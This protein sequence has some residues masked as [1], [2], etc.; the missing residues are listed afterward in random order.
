[1]QQRIAKVLLHDGST[2]LVLCRMEDDHYVI[3]EGPVV[4]GRWCR[5]IKPLGTTSFT[6]AKNQFT[7]AVTARRHKDFGEAA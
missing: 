4:N 2:D 1:M 3:A 5:E 6:N 7:E